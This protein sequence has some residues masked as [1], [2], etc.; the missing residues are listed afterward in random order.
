MDIAVLQ[1]LFATYHD[2]LGNLFPED[3]P[4]RI[5]TVL[6]L[7]RKRPVTQKEL[8]NLFGVKQPA[9][10][11]LLE[12]LHREG[13]GDYGD[14]TKDGS[15]GFMLTP[16]GCEVLDKLGTAL[17]QCIPTETTHKRSARRKST[18]NQR[19]KVPRRRRDAEGQLPLNIK[20]VR[21]IERPGMQRAKAEMST[22][23]GSKAKTVV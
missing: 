10:A 3:E 14:R 4:T 9:I 16:A 22:T 21:L 2:H 6:S 7:C 20:D 13:L 18:P 1:Q 15:K 23:A 17:D 19:V 5:L 12:K 11:K 8:V